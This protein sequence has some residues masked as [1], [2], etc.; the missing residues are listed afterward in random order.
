[1]RETPNRGKN[2]PKT[3]IVK[4]SAIGTG[5]AFIFLGA[6]SVPSGLLPHHMTIE[7][8]ATVMTPNVVNTPK[9]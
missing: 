7:L 3:I 1:M 6:P 8:I 2:K 5:L 4:T 9:N